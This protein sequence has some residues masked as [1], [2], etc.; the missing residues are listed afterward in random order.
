HRK[1]AFWSASYFSFCHYHSPKLHALITQVEREFYLL[2]TGWGFFD[3]NIYALAHSHTHLQDGTP[4]LKRW[5]DSRAFEQIPVFVVG[6]GPSL[7]QS[8]EFIRQHQQQAIIIACGT[9]VSALYKVG[10]KPDI[11]VAVERTKS[12]ADFLS[13][14]NA[15][16]FIKDT[17]FLSVDVIHP[18]CKR[19]FRKTGLAFKPNE[20]MFSM[21][22][23]AFG[24]AFEYDTIE[25]SNPFVGN[26]GL[27]YAALLGFKQVYLFG[28]DNGYKTAGQH[29][30]SL[31]LY[32]NDKQEAKYE[33]NLKDTFPAPG[34]FGDEVRINHLFGLAIHNMASV[35]RD[36]PE[37]QCVNSS[38]GA[39]IEGAI[40]RRV[41]SLQ[42]EWP[43]L[44]KIPLM[45]EVM[46]TCFQSFDMSSVD[47]AA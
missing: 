12:S 42:P 21:L 36:Y 29:H 27:N 39:Y 41:E 2:K 9:A 28:I 26:T 14:L 7:D 19:F 4:F 20:P 47:F 35:L 15:D 1:G 11:Y 24:Q 37:I 43:V 3:D 40:P 33:E 25:F 38:D 31:S 16:D 30:S 6:N 10:V 32:Y 23:S 18:E 45:D 46:A 17:V 13:I 34:N 5:R 22:I 8:I 44:D